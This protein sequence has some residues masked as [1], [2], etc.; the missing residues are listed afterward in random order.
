[1]D[2]FEGCEHFGH[3]FVC[4]ACDR[5]FRSVNHMDKTMLRKIIRNQ[6]AKSL[7]LQAITRN[8]RKL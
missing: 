8:G 6:N 4:K 7:T 1:M 2:W 3:R 5:P